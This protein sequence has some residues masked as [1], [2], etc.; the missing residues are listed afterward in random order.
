L[1]VPA[2]S[3]PLISISRL[4]ADNNV[5]V[6]FNTNSCTVKDQSSHETLLQGTK[7]DGL[8]VVSSVS[9]EA[10]LCEKNLFQLWHQRLCH[11]SLSVLQHQRFVI[12]VV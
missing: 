11:A 1:H 12:H 7:H 9:P 5:Y 6:E 10:F 4:I 3:K 2:I 8:Y